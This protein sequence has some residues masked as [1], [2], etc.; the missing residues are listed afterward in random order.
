MVI[1]TLCIMIVPMM[2]LTGLMKLTLWQVNMVLVATFEYDAIII[3][4]RGAEKVPNTCY[5]V[6]C[7]WLIFIFLNRSFFSAFFYSFNLQDYRRRCLWFAHSA[8]R[9]LLAFA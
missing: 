4:K 7:Q 3:P 2:A 8:I 9:V 5:E 6:T 1:M